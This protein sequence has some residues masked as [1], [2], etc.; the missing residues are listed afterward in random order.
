MADLD[1]WSDSGYIIYIFFG[2][3][4]MKRFAKSDLLAATGKFSTMHLD[5]G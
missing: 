4:S 3:K 2:L 1:Y 5:T